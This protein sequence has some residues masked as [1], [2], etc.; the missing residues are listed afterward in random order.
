MTLGIK[1]FTRTL[2]IM[3]MAIFALA[4]SAQAALIDFSTGTAGNGGSISTDGTYWY[5]T[6]IPLNLLSVSGTSADGT[7]DLT[8]TGDG[9]LAGTDCCAVLSF[10]TQAN[11][12]TVVGGIPLLGIVD[13]TTLLSGSFSTFSAT[14]QQFG[15]LS[16]SGGGLDSK[17]TG[18]LT[19]LGLPTDTQFAFFGFTI[20]VQS[21]G[22]GGYY[23][24][25]TDILNRSVP[26]PGLLALFGLGL[27]GVG[28]KLARRGV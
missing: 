2:A 4:G 21:T 13:G 12:I 19:A 20:G 15:F 3:A 17:D 1:T 16:V 27:L 7:Y 23:A 25:S 14:P 28:R 24:S 22:A 10:D 26:E 11:T 18:L 8:G 5:G 9:S 6:G